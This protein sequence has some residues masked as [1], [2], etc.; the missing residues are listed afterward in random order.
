[1]IQIAGKSEAIEVIRLIAS[2]VDIRQIQYQRELKVLQDVA[3]VIASFVLKLPFGDPIPVDVCSL[4]DHL[5][6]LLLAPF[7]DTTSRAFPKPPADKKLSFFPS[8]PIVQGTPEYAADHTNSSRTPDDADSCRKYSSSHPTLTPGIFTLYCPHAVCYGFE[9][10]RSHKSPRHPFDI[11]LTRFEQ[12]PTTIIYDNSCIRKLH[13][14]V[15]NRHPIHFQSTNYFLLIAFTGVVTLVVQAAILLT[16]TCIS[17][18]RSTKNQ[19]KKV[20][21]VI[22]MFTPHLPALGSI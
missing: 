4:L 2:G 11:F 6:E 9:V 12:P 20:M 21:L 3:P 7:Q 15:L 5:C 18:C 19:K 14:Y 1:M 22:S 8:L 10:M 16:D 13:Q 17:K